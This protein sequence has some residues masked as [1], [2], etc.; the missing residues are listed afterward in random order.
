MYAP[1]GGS[2][3][4]QIFRWAVVP[5]ENTPDRFKVVYVFK[6]EIRANE[7]ARY[8]QARVLTAVVAD[9]ILAEHWPSQGAKSDEEGA[10]RD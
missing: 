10:S 7:F 3:M 5:S 1:T 4:P 9:G 8:T 2:M 6:D